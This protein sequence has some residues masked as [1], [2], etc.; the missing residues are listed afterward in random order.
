MTHEELRV[1]VESIDSRNAEYI[2]QNYRIQ[3]EFEQ[4]NRWENA[5]PKTH[6][7]LKEEANPEETKQSLIEMIRRELKEEIEKFDGRHLTPANVKVG[8]GV[9]VNLYSDRHAG[10]VVKVTKS[11]ITI[12]RDKATL[13][14][15]FKPEWIVGG[16][17]GHC[18]NQDEQTYTYERDENGQIYTIRWSKAYNKYGRPGNL[19]ASK[20][21]H[22]FY[23]YN[24]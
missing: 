5:D 2:L 15:N 9:T 21:R 22:E 19:T 23:D 8:D 14:P 12:Q 18:T 10:T 4:L 3:N 17:A 16:F 1:M 11:S 7:L 20:G 24:Y 6:W 13:D